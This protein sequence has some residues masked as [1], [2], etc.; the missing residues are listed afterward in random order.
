MIGSWQLLLAG[1]LVSGIGSGAIG[2]GVIYFT[3]TSSIAA[4][5]T[6]IGYYRG[7]QVGIMTDYFVCV[8]GGGGNQGPLLSQKTNLLGRFRL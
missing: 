3:V 2:L 6:V 4:R 5:Q 8:C 1:R 7:S